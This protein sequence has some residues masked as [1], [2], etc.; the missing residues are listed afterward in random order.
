[1]YVG[2]CVGGEPC[3]SA[4][5]PPQLK[6]LKRRG[7]SSERCEVARSP[8]CGYCTSG[9]GR[10]SVGS[11]GGGGVGLGAELARDRSAY[12]GRVVGVDHREDRNLDGVEVGKVASAR[13]RLVV[14]SV[15]ASVYIEGRLAAPAAEGLDMRS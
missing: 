12:G 11:P 9:G 7:D 4:K 10:R 5:P 15:E 3:R 14:G 1:M 13:P 2:W 8:T 6:A